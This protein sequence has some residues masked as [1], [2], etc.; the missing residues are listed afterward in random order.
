[1]NLNELLKLNNDIAKDM[2]VTYRANHKLVSL[3]VFITLPFSLQLGYLIEYFSSKHNI[4]IAVDLTNIYVYYLNPELNANEII[5]N[6]NKTGKW[7]D[8]IYVDNDSVV[9]NSLDNY[10]NAFSIIL[11]KLLQP[12]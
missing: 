11:S 7:T 6:Y 2:L 3:Q 12:F 5:N 10:Y 9:S 8:V 4:G 1:M